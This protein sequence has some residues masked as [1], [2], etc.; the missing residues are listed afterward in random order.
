MG[1]VMDEQQTLDSRGAELATCGG[2]E[3][4][5]ALGEPCEDPLDDESGSR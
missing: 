4:D 5:E 2:D 3:V 1:D